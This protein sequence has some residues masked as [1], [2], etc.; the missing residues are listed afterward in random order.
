M[1]AE[2]VNGGSLS[3]FMDPPL[4]LSQEVF[5]AVGNN[6]LRDRASV[7]DLWIRILEEYVKRQLSYWEDRLPALAGIVIPF[8]RVLGADEAYILGLWLGD[9]PR[10]LAWYAIHTK[11][12][13]SEEDGDY[14]VAPAVREPGTWSWASMRFEVY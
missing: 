8:Q 6:P 14:I 12:T 7:Y 1:D 4:R 11:A 13:D 9:M 3:L 10:C 5:M 2:F